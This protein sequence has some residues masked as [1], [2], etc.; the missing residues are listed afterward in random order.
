VID[1]VGIRAEHH[2]VWERL[3][4]LTAAATAGRPAVV[5]F[6]SS[7]IDGMQLTHPTSI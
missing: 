3:Q 7:H 5:P 1:A 2:A 6:R 4:R